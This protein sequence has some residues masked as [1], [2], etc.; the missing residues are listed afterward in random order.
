MP[1][2]LG[3]T[4]FR[5]IIIDGRDSVVTPIIKE[6]TT[7]SRAPFASKASAMGIVPK[8][9]AYIGT[10][11]TVARITPKGLHQSDFPTEN[12]HKQTRLPRSTIGEDMR[13][14]NVTPSGSPAL[15]KPIN[16]GIDEQEQNGVTVP[17][18]RQRCLH[19]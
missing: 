5:S 11:A 9:S 14:E 8:I 13:K 12:A 17:A 10:P 18:R 6:R 7:P 1:S 4:A 2:S 3:F 16:N 19:P 15:V